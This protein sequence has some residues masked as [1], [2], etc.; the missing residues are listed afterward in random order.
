MPGTPEGAQGGGATGQAAGAV[1]CHTAIQRAMARIVNLESAPGRLNAFISFDYDDALRQADAV[2]ER[3]ASRGETLPLAA[4]PVAVKDNFCTDVLPT[5]CASRLLHG[6]QSPFEATVVRRLR[7]AGAVIVGKTNLD[8]FGMGSSTE[9][10]A[11]G[12]TRNPH[13]A[14][15]VAGGSSGGSAAAVA[16]R[17]VPVAIGSDTGGSVRQP[18]SYCGVVGLKPTYGRVSRYG[19]VAFASSLDHV[20]VLGGTVRD[21]ALV[22]R[23]V[24]GVDRHDATSTTAPVPDYVAAVEGAEASL[25]GLVIGTPVEYFGPALDEGVRARCREA[26]DHLRRL[27]ATVR[28]VSLP[29]TPLAPLAYWVLAAAE[30]ASNLARFDGVRFGSRPP[31]VAPAS[32]DELVRATRSSFGSEVTRRILLGTLISAGIEGAS[33]L[34]QAR[35]ARQLVARD[36]AATFQG[37]DLLFTPATPAPAFRVG[38]L[39]NRPL[40][41][42]MSDQY[43]VAANLAGVPAISIPVGTVGG[44]PV[45]GQLVAPHLQEATLLRAAAV[46]ERA[47]RA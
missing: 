5:T 15:R 37:V 41:M 36:L 27:G 33:F 47:L 10:S 21:V 44:L 11:F 28:K 3:I 32:G 24:A 4:T 20:G 35:R 1:D 31:G 42:D 14:R 29:H 7:A 13:D 6:Y 25:A 16:A 43:L 17:L 30:A 22:L 2:D 39:R 46:L 38:E 34:K 40:S 12:P 9:S 8:E 18:A 19:L 26:L 23:C 45:G